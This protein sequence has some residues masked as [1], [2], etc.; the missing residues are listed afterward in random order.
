MIRL[1]YTATDDPFEAYLYIKAQDI[2]SYTRAWKVHSKKESHKYRHH[3]D[4]ACIQYVMNILKE[5][6]TYHP[7]TDPDPAR[8]D[9]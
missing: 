6:R 8:E 3:T 1:G 9:P 2:V 5:V 7:E 4:E